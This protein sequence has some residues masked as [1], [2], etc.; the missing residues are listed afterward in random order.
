MKKLLPLLIFACLFI[1]CGSEDDDFKTRLNGNWDM[2]N[3]VSATDA[4]QPTFTPGEITWTINGDVVKVVN[5]VSDLYP[6]T[7]PT[8][9]YRAEVNPNQKTLRIENGA[10]NIFYNYSV[11]NRNLLSLTQ[12]GGVNEVHIIFN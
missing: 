9:E 10:T 3:I 1:A 5:N 6:E 8:G 12:S 7:L 11:S 4:A 2:V